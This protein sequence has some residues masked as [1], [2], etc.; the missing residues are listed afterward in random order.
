MGKFRT[1]GERTLEF[2]EEIEQLEFFQG[3]KRMLETRGETKQFQ[4]IIKV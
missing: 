2:Q 3:L 4:S 1:A